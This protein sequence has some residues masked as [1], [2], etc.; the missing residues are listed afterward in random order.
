MLLVNESVGTVTYAEACASCAFEI[1][2]GWKCRVP[3]QAA[4]SCE[5]VTERERFTVTMW[6]EV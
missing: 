1:Q 6:D 3:G 2:H 5:H 4:L